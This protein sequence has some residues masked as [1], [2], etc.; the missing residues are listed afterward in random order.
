MQRHFMPMLFCA[1]LVISNALALDYPTRDLTVIIPSGAG[2]ATDIAFR[3]FTK[4]FQ[5]HFKKSVNIINIGGAGGSVGYNEFL[6]E[7][8]MSGH[9]LVTQLA[10]MPLNYAIG[11][12]NYTRRDFAPV[13]SVFSGY[14]TLCVRNDSPIKTFDDFK[15]SIKSN[16]DFRYG[17]FSN[18]PSTG[19]LLALEDSLGMKFKV[20]DIPEVGKQSELLAGR[21]EASSDFFA[22]MK[23]FIDSGDFRSLGVFHHER[24]PAYPDIPTFK[25]MGV[26]YSIT[27]QIIGLFADKGTPSEIIAYIDKAVRETFAQEPELTKDFENLGYIGNYKSTDDYIAWLDNIFSDF[28]VKID[29]ME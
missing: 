26:D 6:K 23:P 11:T 4:H 19:V 20:I 8:D 10:S 1:I 22:Q 27:D 18:S 24:L 25:E 2:G 21:L 12:F 5:K 14:M 29:A 16:P 17:V 7:N 15:K 13:C 3:S 28:K 9:T